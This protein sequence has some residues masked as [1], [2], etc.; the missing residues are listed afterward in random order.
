M[1]LFN[2]LAHSQRIVDATK[3]QD[4]PPWRLAP[5]L[6]L[7]RFIS[8]KFRIVSMP[9]LLFVEQPE[10]GEMIKR[11]KG[12]ATL[13]YKQIFA[14]VKMNYPN[15]VVTF[16]AHRASD[17]QKDDS[18][19]TNQ[20]VQAGIRAQIEIAERS[21]ESML[22]QLDVTKPEDLPSTR[23]DWM[24]YVDAG[25]L[26]LA[27]YAS[28]AYGFNRGGAKVATSHNTMINQGKFDPAKLWPDEDFRKH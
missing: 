25:A 18:N 24:L 6:I 19:I 26:L 12:S 7:Q 3:G 10:T 8:D 22:Q 1:L 2:N 17:K 20:A 28:L 15:Q 14:S 11:P 21:F 4:N 23:A 5:G 9:H 16:V 13:F 27:H